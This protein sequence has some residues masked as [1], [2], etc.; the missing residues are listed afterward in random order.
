MCAQAETIVNKVTCF[1]L[2]CHIMRKAIESFHPDFVTQGVPTSVSKK[3]DVKVARTTIQ[4]REQ[5]LGLQQ[6]TFQTVSGPGLYIGLYEQV[7]VLLLTSFAS[8]LFLAS[9]SLFVLNC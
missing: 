6:P 8:H 2:C 7:L 5:K 3:E 4:G 1:E 9:Q